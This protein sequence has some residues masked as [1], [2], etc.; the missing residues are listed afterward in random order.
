M[1]ERIRR[2][3]D[4]AIIAML[5]TVTATGITLMVIL[6]LLYPSLQRT[7]ANLERASGAAAETAENFAAA[8]AGVAEDLSQASG[9]INDTTANFNAASET[10]RLNSLDDSI[11]ETII[12][13]LT[14]RE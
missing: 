12:R 11:S 14:G 13:L 2:I 8:S 4:I 7:V 6:A 9:N 5:A 10:F 1:T 3:K